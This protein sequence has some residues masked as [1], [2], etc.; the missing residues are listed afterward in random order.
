MS[1][2]EARIRELHDQFVLANTHEDTDWL[3]EHITEDVS[4]FNL[5]KSNYFG[6]KAI[7]RLW[8][9]LYEQKPDKDKDATIV[10]TDRIIKVV[11]DAAV[12]AYNMAIDYDFGDE[13]QFHHGGRG[14]EVWIRTDGEF[15]LAHFHC[16]EHEAGHMEGL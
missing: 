13:A 10:V 16:S 3:S 4:W 8:S 11:G 7:L 9:W 15:K 12:V 1:A 2:D 6:D 5:N 14:T